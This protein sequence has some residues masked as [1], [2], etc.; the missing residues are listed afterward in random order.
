MTAGLAV[1]ISDGVGD[2]SGLVRENHLGL[3]LDSLNPQQWNNSELLIFFQ[4]LMAHRNKYKE[5][6]V[7][8][9]KKVFV[10]NNYLH[11]YKE[12]L[13]NIS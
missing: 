5:R 6:N 3:V 11:Q 4:D 12:A 7:D 8:F 10:R 9:A 1:V 13:G 2:L